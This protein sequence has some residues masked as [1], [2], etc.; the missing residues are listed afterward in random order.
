MLLFFLGAILPDDAEQMKQ[1]QRWRI[2][3][4]VPL[5]TATLQVLFFL[6]VIKEEPIGF[7]ISMDRQEEARSLLKKV[8]L[9]GKLSDEEFDNK[10]DEQLRYLGRSTSK[11]SSF[12]KFNQAVC[13]PTY[14]KATWVCCILNVFNQQSG[15]GILTVY[16]TRLLIL[17]H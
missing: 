11:E 6:F 17:I 1:D 12:I 9:Q 5:L 13:G 2:I 15:I 4:A 16:A 8:Y 7:C 14:R 3:Y 10:I